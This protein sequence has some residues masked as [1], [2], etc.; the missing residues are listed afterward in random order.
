VV[1]PGGFR[2]AWDTLETIL[3]FKPDYQLPA[4][5]QPGLAFLCDSPQ[6]VDRLYVEL[7]AEGFEGHKAPWDAF[8]G[9]RYA[10][11]IDPDNRIVDLFATL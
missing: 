2:I 9:Q 5:P 11:L 6:E 7:V 3:S 8:W 10:L 4:T 1:L